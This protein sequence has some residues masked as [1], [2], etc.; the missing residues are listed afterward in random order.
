MRKPSHLN[1][2]V[3]SV[4]CTSQL[5]IQQTWQFNYSSV[6]SGTGPSGSCVIAHSISSPRTVNLRKCHQ[7]KLSEPS[8]MVFHCSFATVNTKVEISLF[9]QKYFEQG[10]GVFYACLD[11]EAVTYFFLGHHISDLNKAFILRRDSVKIRTFCH[12]F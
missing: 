7:V 10:F 9:L 11:L 1:K 8:L 2:I 4:Q 3:K 12:F 6:L 5:L